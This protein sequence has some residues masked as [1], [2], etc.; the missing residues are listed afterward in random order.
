LTVSGQLEAEIFATSLGDCY[1]FGPTFRAENS[2]TT[3]HLAEFWMVEPEMPFY[4]L[5][6][7][8][9]LAEEFIRT[10][11][12]DVLKNCSEDMEFFN[13][14]IDNTVLETLRNITESEF[15]R[16]PY[17]EAVEIL[18]KCGRQFEYLVEWGRDLQSEHERYLTEEHFKQ[19][20][21]LYDYPRTIK[22][23]YMRCNADGKTVR[24]MDVLVPRVGE[25]IGGSQREERYDVLVDRMRECHLNPDDYWWYVDLR[26]YG[27]VPHSG[28][29]LGLE[30]TIQL[31]TGMT[32]IRDCIPFPRTPK[33]AEF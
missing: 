21:I 9:R 30:R 29:G 31:I 6:D 33:N 10:V 3:R 24:A 22:P 26:R 7:N 20:V 19:P 5:D 1:T 27:T 2:N 12:G 32:N 8:M 17:T 15:I 11:V 16:L 14:R 4:E 25:I 28:F 13:Q 23:F 18:T